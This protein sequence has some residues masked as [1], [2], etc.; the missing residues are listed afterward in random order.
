VQNQNTSASGVKQA[1]SDFREQNAGPT[2]ALG[3]IRSDC[4]SSSIPQ[5]IAREHTR[6]P[7]GFCDFVTGHKSRAVRRAHLFNRQ[8]SRRGESPAAR[9]LLYEAAVSTA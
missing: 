5:K 2:A 6:K 4:R 7:S 9:A 8:I 1:H 3:H